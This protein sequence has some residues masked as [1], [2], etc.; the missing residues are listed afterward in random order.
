MNFKDQ[1]QKLYFIALVPGNPVQHE[2]M[3]FK[4][5]A[6]N[7]FLSSRSLNSPAHITIV[8]PFNLALND[9]GKLSAD[10]TACL[11]KVED[12]Y[13][14]LNGFGHFGQKVIFVDVADNQLITDINKRLKKGLASYL[15]SEQ[16]H[17]NKFHPHITVAFKDLMPE[18]FQ[19]AWTYFSAIDYHRVIKLDSIVLLRHENRMWK[20]IRSFKF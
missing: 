4:E 8:P 9:E 7:M 18:K 11:G 19:M 10:I 6:R 1:N 12:F 13:I 3:Q 17:D 2:I 15:N 16:N 5:D 14:E 20:I